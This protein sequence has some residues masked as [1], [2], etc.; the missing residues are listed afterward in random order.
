MKKIILTAVAV[1]AFSLS[2]AQGMRFGLKA[3]LN[4]A[5]LNGD[6]ENVKSKIGFNGGGFA[7]FKVTEK[8]AVQPELLFSLQGADAEEGDGSINLNYINI[9]VMAKYYVIEG[10][11]LQAGP[12]IGF[13]MT[14]EA[15]GGGQDV[16]IKDS[17][18]SID[19]GL[20]F[21]A[22]YDIT[23]NIFADVRYNL[24][25]TTL[26]KDGEVKTQ[27]GVFQIGVGYSF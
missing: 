14:A 9:P 6:I 19:F 11:S 2:N 12:Q 16:D 13:L 24:G 4:M 27:N 18:S 10:L 1:M 25:L 23:K 8:F 3:G 26:D 15:S 22:G 7:E 21:G 20:N 5:S 17:T